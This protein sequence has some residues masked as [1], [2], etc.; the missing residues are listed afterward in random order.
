VSKARARAAHPYRE[1]LPSIQ[2]QTA[3]A[4]ALRVGAKLDPRFEAAERARAEAGKSIDASELHTAA[5]SSVARLVNCSQWRVQVAS[6]RV[7]TDCRGK[8]CSPQFSQ[9]KGL[10]REGFGRNQLT[11]AVAR[12]TTVRRSRTADFGTLY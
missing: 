7:Q 5:I 4:E 8:N 10:L 9:N 6:Q 11:F 2:S 1:A 3:M 12:K